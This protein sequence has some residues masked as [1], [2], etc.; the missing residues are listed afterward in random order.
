VTLRIED[1]RPAR[2]RLVVDY[3]G[4]VVQRVTYTLWEHLDRVEVEA[5]VDLEALDPVELTEE[6]GLAFPFAPGSADV[7]LGVL[8]GFITPSER[9]EAVGHEAFSLRQSIAFTDATPDSAHT[10]VWAARD[11]RVVKLPT[12]AQE[13]EPTL[14]AVLANHFPEAW[15]RNEENEGVWPLRF[16]FTRQSGGFDAAFA[17]G[18]G[19]GFAQEPVVYPTWL[20]AEEPVRRVLDLG[21]DPVHL[22][23]FQ[24]EVQGRRVLVRLQNPRPDAPAS[25]RVAV[26]GFTIT[27]AERVTFLGGDP[28]PLPLNGEAVA[29]SIEPSEVVTLR[30]Q[31]D[32]AS[33]SR[34]PASYQPRGDS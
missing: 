7:R 21:G 23:A 2:L 13:T 20:T 6:Y 24:P 18:F 4:A 19:R 26:P 27:A 32:G 22:L 8:G 29:V 5:E 14:V 28:T 34:T 9:F 15:N 31:L 30:L 10:I 17:D 33:A 25:V 3:V 1:E 16:A 11:S 12:A